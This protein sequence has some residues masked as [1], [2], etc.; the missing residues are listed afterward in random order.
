MCHALCSHPKQQERAANHKEALKKEGSVYSTAED[1][2][3]SLWCTSQQAL[4]VCHAALHPG[5]NLHPMR[6]A[7]WAYAM[8]PCTL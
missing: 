2:Y 5:R 6:M 3:K 1:A 4:C 8:A 7:S